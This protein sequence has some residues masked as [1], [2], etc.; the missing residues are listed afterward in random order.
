VKVICEWNVRLPEKNGVAKEVGFRLLQ[1]LRDHNKFAIERCE[2]DRA[3]KERWVDVTEW[4]QA[5][6]LKNA[7]EAGNYSG[8]ALLV[9]ALLDLLKDK[10]VRNEAVQGYVPAL[11]PPLT[12]CPPGQQNLTPSY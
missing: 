9:A 8:M 5:F 7:I 1:D 3:G 6:S 10:Q 12:Y 11:P 4:N 2:F